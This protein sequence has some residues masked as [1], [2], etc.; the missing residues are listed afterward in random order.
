VGDLLQQV[1][2][3][4]AGKKTPLL[5]EIPVNGEGAPFLISGLRDWVWIRGSRSGII[6]SAVRPGAI[7]KDIFVQVTQEVAKKGAA[8]KWGNTLPFS[9]DGLVKATKYIKSYDIDQVE[10]LV[11]VGSTLQAPKGVRLSE[12]AWIPKNKAVVVPQDRTYLGLLGTFGPE[13]YT[14]VLHNPSRGMVVL[15]DW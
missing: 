10:A 9:D 13:F 15:G 11:P 6:R 14:V 2:M 8:S 5:I 12:S 3:V 7:P 4:S 1:P